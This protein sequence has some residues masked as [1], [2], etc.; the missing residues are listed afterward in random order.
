M[1]NIHSTQNKQR[2]IEQEAFLRNMMIAKLHYLEEQGYPKDA[3]KLF[4]HLYEKLLT[5]N[6]LTEHGLKAMMTTIEGENS[7][8]KRLDPN[9]REEFYKTYHPDF[10]KIHYY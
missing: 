8:I 4:E 5:N 3:L 10:H 9:Q 1:V 6:R 7:H 2:T